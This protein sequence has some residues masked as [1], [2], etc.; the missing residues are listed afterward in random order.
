MERNASIFRNPQA[1]PRVFPDLAAG[2]ATHHSCKSLSGHQ[3]ACLERLGGTILTD[4][5]LGPHKLL[6]SKRAKEDP[7]QQVRRGHRD[8]QQTVVAG[9]PLSF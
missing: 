4:T 8:H 6:L 7:N 9:G 3:D 5:G 1:S 2:T